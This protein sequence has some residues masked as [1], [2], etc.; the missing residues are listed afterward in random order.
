M[1][2]SDTH[3]LEHTRFRHTAAKYLNPF[4]SRSLCRGTCN[5]NLHL[6]RWVGIGEDV[7][8]ETKLR[9]FTKDTSYHLRERILEV[10]DRKWL[11]CGGKKPA[12]HLMEDVHVTT[13]YLIFP[14]H[15]AVA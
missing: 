15:L 13:I 3:L 8:I 12:A 10:F 7:R 1:V 6:K 2:A 9:T 4:T 11:R 5:T 14:V